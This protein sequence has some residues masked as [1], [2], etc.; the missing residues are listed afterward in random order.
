[1]YTRIL[2]AV[3]DDAISKQALQEAVKLAKDQQAKLRIIYV[4]D[5]FIPGGEGIHVDFKQHEEKV[6]KKGQSL[7]NKMTAAAKKN[8]GQ[9]ES[10]L[11]EVI[12]SNDHISEKIL[13]EAHDWE[14]DLIILGTHGR[15]GISRLL[16]GSV[17]EE[18][19]RNAD[20]PVQLIHGED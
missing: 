19:V 6:R 3:S 4:A 18:V 12:D 15:S 17:A 9:V 16:L 5:E 8:Y 20:V 10:K 11:V 1:M 2:V 14:A 13:S 7:L